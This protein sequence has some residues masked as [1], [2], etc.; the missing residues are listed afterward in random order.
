MNYDSAQSCQIISDIPD[1]TPILTN[2]A[3]VQT[4]THS[5]NESDVM[6][7]EC[8]LD[9]T[10]MCVLVDA[11]YHYTV[12]KVAPKICKQQVIAKG[13][14]VFGHDIVILIHPQD[15]RHRVG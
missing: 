5:R 13:L 10:R 2:E 1:R 3:S 11:R 4:V 6:T 15:C 9:R 14:T 12:G 7:V 8:L